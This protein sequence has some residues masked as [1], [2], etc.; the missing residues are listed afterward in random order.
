MNI[1]IVQNKIADKS[2]MR[3][4]G[5]NLNKKDARELAKWWNANTVGY[6]FVHADENNIGR[7]KVV[8]SIT[9][10]K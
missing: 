7:Y 9:S 8:R 2:D 10:S 6:Y 5:N 1:K 4:I 3:M